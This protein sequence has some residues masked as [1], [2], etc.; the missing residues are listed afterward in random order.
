MTYFLI[1]PEVAGGL[2]ERCVINSCVHPPIV[3][4]LHYQMDGWLG[5]N[6]LESFPAFIVTEQAADRLK[7]SGF[8]GVS[9]DEAEITKSAQFDDLYPGRAIP[10]FVWLKV[11]GRAG[12]DDFGLAADGRLVVSRRALADLQQIGIANA[13]VEPFG[14]EA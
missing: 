11:C 12:H 2:G 6:L 7:E 4:K 5:D 13:I 9:F 14:D 8:T 1:E 10:R 3:E